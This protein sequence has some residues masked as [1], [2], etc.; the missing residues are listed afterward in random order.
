VRQL[1]LQGLVV[2]LAS[3]LAASLGYG[4]DEPSPPDASE[5]VDALL[6]G[7]LGFQEVSGEELE[8]EV[9]DLGEVP[10]R[11]PVPLDFL[12]RGQ[13][14][15]YLTEV[16][17]AEYPRA[18]ADADARTLVAFGLLEPGTDL[19]ALR[20]R[21]LEQNIAGFYDDRPGRKKL[22]AVSASRTL[23]PMNQ[24]VLSHELRHALQD[25]YMDTHSL[26]DDSIGDYDDRRLALLCLLEGDATFLM[27][28]FMLARLPGAG[29]GASDLAGGVP[30]PTP[31]VE[32]APPV[33]R[34]QLVLPYTSGA[35]LVRTI[36]QQGGWAA[37]R[38][39]WDRP[40]ASTEQVLHPSKYVSD[41][42]PRSVE[43]GYAPTG[44]PVVKAGVL[45]EMLA[46]TLLGD[47]GTEDG[48]S[49]WGGDAFRV[50][51]LG[52]R[53]LLVWRAVWDT[54]SDGRAFAQRLR[55]HLGAI[56]GEPKPVSGFDV[57]GRG[58]WRFAV[59]GPGGF[60]LV[61]SSDDEKALASALAALRLP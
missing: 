31:P 39:A 47:D 46:R 21:I 40:P 19:R 18:Q 23:T 55:S 61:V 44:A 29:E 42:A 16:L 58:P 53:T 54:P 37:V 7:F 2:V 5:L 4:Q 25:Q 3:T 50:F 49:G 28:R 43:V 45:G 38:R 30:L 36:W 11:S 48:A 24:I 60:T 33:V 8:K 27:E 34:D 14:A 35:E 56:H 32:G 57:Y 22:Y 51:D 10:F 9:A 13:L 1:R 26:L 12:D 6:T 20:A 41:E 52:G 17:D 15:R 59:G